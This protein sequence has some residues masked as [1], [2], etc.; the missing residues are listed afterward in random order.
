MSEKAVSIVQLMTDE[1]HP[2]FVRN[3]YQRL[4]RGRKR[5]M[6]ASLGGLVMLE[7]GIVF[8]SLIDPHGFSFAELLETALFMAP[9]GALL[10]YL[11]IVAAFRP[12]LIY[13]KRMSA[14]VDSLSP[15]GRNMYERCMV[16][17][18]SPFVGDPLS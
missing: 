16:L 1:E 11:F 13:R 15:E 18:R 2:H 9:L 10:A 6:K 14:V 4:L 8:S 5:T 17:L 3:E 12:D 7:M